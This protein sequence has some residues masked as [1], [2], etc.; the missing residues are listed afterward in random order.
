MQYSVLARIAKQPTADYPF[1]VVP[2]VNGKE[3]HEITCRTRRDCLL[4]GNG[5]LSGMVEFANHSGAYLGQDRP[6]IA[7]NVV[8]SDQIT[9]N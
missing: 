1:A 6:E 3:G 4:V 7:A 2:V 9:G 5:M 8:F